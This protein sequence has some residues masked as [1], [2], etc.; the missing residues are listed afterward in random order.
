M[1]GLRAGEATAGGDAGAD[2]PGWGPAVRVAARALIPG[3]ILVLRHRTLRG[4]DGLTAMRAV[5]VNF[6]VALGLINLVVWFTSSG[7]GEAGLSGTA[8]GLI[9]GAVGVTTVLIVWFLRRP[10]DCASD[11]ALA[12]SYRTRFFVRVAFADVPA[13]VGFAVSAPTLNPA[14][15][16]LGLAFTAIGFARLAPTAGRLATDQREL[17]R[18]GCGRSL[19]RALRFGGPPGPPPAGGPA[20]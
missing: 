14:M 7:P 15:Y 10:L 12:G 17:D 2:D 18:S 11:A 19:V 5:M 1:D 4:V 20:G 8:G 13:L 9:V 16:P 3:M 6:A